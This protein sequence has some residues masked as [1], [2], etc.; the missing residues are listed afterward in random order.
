[1]PDAPR[2]SKAPA[3]RPNFMLV[4]LYVGALTIVF[5]ICFSLPAL[6]EGARSLPPGPAELTEAELQ[7]ARD[8]VRGALSGGRLIL[9]FVAAGAAVAAGIWTR[10]LPGFRGGG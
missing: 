6:V 4:V 5:G 3:F 7:Q 10:T 9:S 2:R 1:M 8:L